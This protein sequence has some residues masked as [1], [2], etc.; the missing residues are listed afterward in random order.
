MGRTA[1]VTLLLLAAAAA[2]STGPPRSGPSAAAGQ[3]LSTSPLIYSSDP[4]DA[5]NRIFAALFTRVVRTRMT[6]E[7]AGAGPF[8]DLGHPATMFGP[9]QP[10][11]S[12]RLFDRFE[13]G[14][15][16][17]DP[18]YSY[19]LPTRTGQIWPAALQTSMT[20][21]FNERAVRPALHRALMQMD[22]WAAYDR[23]A[24]KRPGPDGEELLRLMARLM[25]KIALTPEEI[26]ALPDH[27]AAAV[28][29]AGLPDILSSGAG[30]MEIVFFPRRTHEDAV[31]LRRAARVFLKP[32][33]PPPDGQT[34][35]KVSDH[36]QP[37]ALAAVAVA[38]QSLLID[39]T[40]RIVPSRLVYQV[41]TR[42]FAPRSE[43]SGQPADVRQFDLSRQRLLATPEAGGF[44]AFSG[45]SPAYFPS[46]WEDYDFASHQTY[47]PGPPVL[48]TL[49]TR[50]SACHHS[51]GHRIAT[52][53]LIY[54]EASAPPVRWLKAPNDERAREVASKKAARED[55]KRLIG[56]WPR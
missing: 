44:V 46:G 51:T 1:C 21:A 48:T 2:Q 5:W 15:R 3:L 14:D 32:V 35:F 4:A 25:R 47:P 7:F 38:M 34:S 50:C 26:A 37:S 55:F 22:L 20:D 31:H 27:Y 41:E 13:G 56:M 49:R 17:I 42:T 8:E 29:R 6:D 24:A 12:T 18:L 52:F 53:S 39:N 33:M 28:R 43:P 45:D 10:R 30:W 54:D 19:V 23:F 40:G 9:G 36:A 16:A 11:I